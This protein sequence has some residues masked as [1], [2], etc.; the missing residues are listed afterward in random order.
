MLAVQEFLMNN[1]IHL[2]TEKWGIEVKET[3]HFY[4]LNYSQFNTPRFIQICEECRGLILDKH[5]YG[6]VSYSFS[7]FYNE[8]E[9]QDPFDLDNS[10]LQ[11]K[12]DGSLLTLYWDMYENKWRVCTR[13]MPFAEGTTPFDHDKTFNDFFWEA[14]ANH[15]DNTDML[16]KNICYMF[17]LVGPENRIMKLYE[18][19]SLYLLG[20]RSLR[21]EKELD[22]FE[23]NM[24]SEL[25]NVPRP[26]TYSFNKRED[27]N[28]I[29]DTFDP[30][31]EG[32]V[33]V[34]YNTMINGNYQRIKIKC[35]RYLALS[36]LVN[37]GG[38]ELLQSKRMFYLWVADGLD[39]IRESFPEYNDKVDELLRRIEQFD[40]DIMSE[41][42]SHY[43][44]DKKEFAMRV[45]GLEW[46]S[47]HFLLHANKL[48]VPSA[49]LKDEKHK[50]MR[51]E[52]F[53]R[54][55]ERFD[56]E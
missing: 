53:I 40:K 29:I 22:Q 28:E 32:F 31:E 37:A 33:A 51:A 17:E 21:E 16:D 46:S 2:L 9:R 39:E 12:L 52:L 6:V 36:K 38:E 41:Y 42:N 27:I 10:V 50:K 56:N 55:C 30:T 14:Y 35:P 18:K 48:E 47:I 3:E 45:K 49:F 25:M 26:K 4:Q 15:I 7:R 54:Y 8:N 13:G 19:P 24:W 23:L 43:V 5:T 34:N 11:E 44:S 1:P 20:A